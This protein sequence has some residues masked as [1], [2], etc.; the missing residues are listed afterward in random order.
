MSPAEC[1]ELCLRKVVDDDSLERATFAF[2]GLSPQ[3]MEQQ[4]GAS[5]RTRN[6][7]L[8]GYKVQRERVNAARAWLESI[9][10]ENDKT[11]AAP[12]A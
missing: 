5:G 4:Y 10:V 2:G 8:D 1:K 3:Q 12:N 7:I 6:E 11:G 9:P